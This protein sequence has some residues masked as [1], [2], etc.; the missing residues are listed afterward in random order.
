M[1]GRPAA[2]LGL[3]LVLSGAIGFWHADW[4]LDSGRRWDERFS[5]RN[6]RL[7]LAGAGRPQNAYYPSLS[8]LPETATF[9]VVN[10][11]AR[12]V[13]AE[14]P[15]RIHGDH[16]TPAT[17]LIARLWS[18]CFILAALALTFRI[19]ELCCDAWTGLMAAGLLAF[20][21][22]VIDKSAILKPD[23][24]LLAA[25]LAAV[26]LA[27]RALAAPSLA[28]FILAG[29][30]VGVAMS[31]K[32]NG[33]PVA[34][35]LVVVAILL[36][37]RKRPV[38]GWLAIAGVVAAGVF[39][40]LNPWLV[41]HP[42][43]Y[44]NALDFQVAHYER[45]GEIRSGG[46]H[47]AQLLFLPSWVT[48]PMAIGLLPGLLAFAGLVGW[49]VVGWRDC[50][51]G[52]SGA[53]AVI[54][55]FLLA[56]TVLYVASSTN[57]VGRNWLPLLPYLALAG[58]W[59]V[60]GS[61]GSWSRRWPTLGRAWLWSPLLALAAILWFLH[62]AAYVYRLQVPTTAEAATSWI[63]SQYSRPGGRLLVAD[64]TPWWDAI[65]DQGKGIGVIESSA[66]LQLPSSLLAGADALLLRASTFDGRQRAGYQAIVRDM[67]RA[68]AN[69]IAPALFE[70]RGPQVVAIVARWKRLNVVS[71]EMAR[72]GHPHQWAWVPSAKL[73]GVPVSF[74]VDVRSAG[75]IDDLQMARIWLGSRQLAR[76]IGRAGER[77]LMIVTA[78][79]KLKGGESLLLELPPGHPMAQQVKV[80]AY[81]W[82]ASRLAGAERK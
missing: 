39:I 78:R 21:P 72:T 31:A 34:F 75:R 30:A 77:R 25:T 38:W 51:R 71:S 18:V 26:W 17:Y 65:A 13:G 6:A 44:R 5:L 8:F 4:R 19:G 15:V 16:A 36:A 33:G 48:S 58:A 53:R 80:K 46:S 12:N 35:G 69:R 23:A 70:R 32:Y 22:Q 82:R 79:A 41:T 3:L 64:V 59:A 14:P 7:L 40:L 66:P 10:G 76:A 54:G 2:W 74:A 47:L 62:G 29:A 45:M 81:R 1:L 55:G 24:L 57:T 37:R 67:P 73:V 49:A 52:H 63:L 11:V 68:D 9:W 27:L 28:R 20:S 56:Y 43:L 60:R 50:L 42:E 61:W